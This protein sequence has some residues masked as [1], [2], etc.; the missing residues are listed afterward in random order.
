MS[1][2]LTA[3]GAEALDDARA[4]TDLVRDARDQVTRHAR[5]R[6]QAVL[7]ANT[8]GASYRT[9]ARAL[10]VRVGNVQQL[11]GAARADDA[12]GQGTDR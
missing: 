4:A 12:A 8:A 3:A 11:V 2:P 7:R 1:R 6:R 10:G 9:I 5:E